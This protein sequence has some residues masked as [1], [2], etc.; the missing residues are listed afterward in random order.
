MKIDWKALLLAPLPFPA[1]CSLLFV[2]TTSGGDPLMGFLILF[3][4]GA[5]IAYAATVGLLLPALFV[6]T[7]FMAMNTTRAAMLGALLGLVLLLPMAWIMW[8]ASGPDSGP[9]LDSFFSYLM[10]DLGDPVMLIFPVGGLVTA[11]L[12]WSLG[13]DAQEA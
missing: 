9:P 4:I 8:R 3:A 5:A 6:T 10:R 7:R 12:Y 13:K 11:M 2:A 1:L